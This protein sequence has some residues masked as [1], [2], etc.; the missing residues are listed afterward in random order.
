MTW[1]VELQNFCTKLNKFKTIIIKSKWLAVWANSSPSKTTQSSPVNIIQTA[2]ILNS[3]LCAQA[4]AEVIQHST[5]TSLKTKAICYSGTKKTTFIISTARSILPSKN[6]PKPRTLLSDLCISTT[7]FLSSLKSRRIISRN[8]S[9][10]G[11]MQVEEE[12]QFVEGYHQ[13]EEELVRAQGRVRLLT[14]F[15]KTI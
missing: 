4:R 14:V 2:Q 10:F 3:H 15:S 8:R 11:L 9:K 13:N 6:K 5:V 7:L 12:A 1:W